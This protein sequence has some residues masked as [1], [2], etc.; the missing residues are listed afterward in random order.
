[1]VVRQAMTLAALGILIGLGAAYGLT[2]FLAPLLF[3][4]KATD[5]VSFLSVP[6]VLAAVALLACYLPARRATRVDPVEA[7]RCQ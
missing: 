3:Q 4:V 5:P 1:M 7:L 2:R 6:L